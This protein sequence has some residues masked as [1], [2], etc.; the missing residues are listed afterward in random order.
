MLTFYTL[1]YY[2][3]YYVRDVVGI[4]NY[5]QATN[6]A[7][8][9][10]ILTAALCTLWTG[11]LSDRIGRRGLVCASGL[12][13]GIAALAFL[14]ARSLPALLVVGVLFGA[15]YGTYLSVDWALITDVLPDSTGIAR[16]MGFWGLAITVPQVL[17]GA[18]GGLIFLLYPPGAKAAYMVLFSVNFIYAALGS[19]LVWQVRG[20]R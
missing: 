5:A 15:G 13:M 7:V 9:V 16:D 20:V 12:A 14:G 3:A 8:A 17:S 1:L 10:T 19:V 6:Y 4:P 18:V 11:R 2:L